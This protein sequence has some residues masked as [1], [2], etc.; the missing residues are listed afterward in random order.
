MSFINSIIKVFVG[1]LLTG[2]IVRKFMKQNLLP[3]LIDH[4]IRKISSVDPM[5][6]LHKVYSIDPCACIQFKDVAGGLQIRFDVTIYLAAKV[7][8]NNI[9]LI[10]LVI[11]IRLFA[12]TAIDGF[13]IR[14]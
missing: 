12:E 6:F 11:P 8:E 14:I 5:A 13:G 3:D 1:D 10:G 9:G 2:E 4:S 7:L